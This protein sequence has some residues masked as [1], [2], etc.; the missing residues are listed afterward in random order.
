MGS[1]Y[2][3]PDANLSGNRAKQEDKNMHMSSESLLI[4]VVVGVAAGWLAGQ[5]VQGTGFGIIG[6][7]IIGVIGAFIG[8]WLLPQLNIHLGSGVVS[9][10]INATIGALLLLFI[11][12]LV[13][14]GGGWGGSWGRSW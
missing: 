7:L 6:D 2:P 8:D 4:I 5:I 12:R 11:L 3:E 13:R 10:I 9:A 1:A 14:R